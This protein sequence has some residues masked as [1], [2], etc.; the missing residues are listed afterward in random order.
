[1]TVS[2]HR[3][4]GPGEG[5]ARRPSLPGVARAPLPADPPVPLPV[6][7]IDAAPPLPSATVS[8]GR[9]AWGEAGAVRSVPVEDPAS[10]SGSLVQAV[11]ETL[12]GSRPAAQL[13]RWL[14]ADLYE[15]LARRAGLAVR[16][17]GRP[18]LVRRAV[19]RHVHVCRVTPV[20]A[21]ASVVVHDGLRVRAAAVRL[22]A[23]RGR[24]RATALE[25]G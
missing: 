25:L 3:A 2:A 16:I 6:A 14:S 9:P 20:V 24:W 17:K 12:S 22:E 18:S 15:S 7:R 11:V 1:M 5:A 4:P 23:H 13:G 21:E 19:V 10:W 8:R